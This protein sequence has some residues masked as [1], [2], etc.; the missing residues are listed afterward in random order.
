MVKN[1]LNRLLHV[2]IPFIVMVMV[3]RVLLLVFGY[4]KFDSSVSELLAFVPAAIIG[5]FLFSFLKFKEEDDKDEE[6]ITPLVPRGKVVAALQTAGAVAVLIA[7]MYA[8]SFFTDGR[9][10]SVTLSVFSV[11]S[12]VFVHPIIEEYVFRGLFYGELRRM[13]RIFAVLAQA[14]M[15]AIVHNTVNGM[16]YALAS[17]V[18]LAVLSELSGRIAPAMAAH[19]VINLRSLMYL[20]CL[21]DKPGA[22]HVIDMSVIAIGCLAFFCPVMIHS[23]RMNSADSDSDGEDSE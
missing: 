23:R 6:H 7:A 9:T 10:E 5:A 15:F 3:Q 20:T 19:M 12:L 4:L 14:V 17:G 21:A 18:V 22:I 2:F 13:N 8:V 11:I 16:I 1:N